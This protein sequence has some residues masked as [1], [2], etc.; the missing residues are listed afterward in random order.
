MTSALQLSPSGAS[1]SYPNSPFLRFLTFQTSNTFGSASSN[2][3]AFGASTTN[4]AFGGGNT[5]TTGF[6]QQ[7]QSSPFGAAPAQSAFGAAPVTSAFSAA[8]ATSAFGATPATSAF[9]AAPG[10]SAFGA[11]PATSGF[12]AAPASSPFGANNNTA[13]PFG[14][15][16]TSSFGAANTSTGIGG[17]GSPQNNMGGS[18]GTG[19]G[20]TPYQPVVS[21]ENNTKVSILAIT[22]SP[23]Y[24]QKSFEELRFE[25]YQKGNKGGHQQAAGGFGGA[26]GFGAS[27]APNAF[28][29]TTSPAPSAFGGGGFGASPAPA[30]GAFGAA[31]ASSAFGAAPAPSAFGAT[32]FGASPTPA[33][34]AFGGFGTPTA[35]PAPSAFGGFGTP[36]AAP[37]PSAFGGFGTPAAAPAPSAFSGFGTP[38]AA[39][40]P[41]LGG[42]GSPAAAP[43]PSAFGGFG[44]P[45]TA[46][47][48]P[49]AFGGFGAA[50]AAAPSAFGGFGA[51]PA[52]AT[53]AFGG[54]GS[55]AAAPAPSA[56]GGFGAPTAAAPATSAFGGFGAAAPA[57]NA[58]ALANPNQILVSDGTNVTSDAN[59]ASKLAYLDNQRQSLVLTASPSQPKL[60][61]NTAASNKPPNTSSLYPNVSANS[62]RSFQAG[63]N[64]AKIRPRLSGLSPVPKS[65][66]LNAPNK[67]L[68]LSPDAYLGNSTKRLVI[69]DGALTPKLKMRLQLT[70]RIS[71]GNGT[72]ASK[73]PQ[74]KNDP[75]P[76]PPT[77]SS[78]G[79]NQSPIPP[80]S[81]TV[82][83]GIPAETPHSM[84]G[85]STPGTNGSA[86]SLAPNSTK[87]TPTSSHKSNTS[88][89]FYNQVVSS[90]SAPTPVQ[91][92]A[93]V[94]RLLNN[95]YVT[96]PPFNEI[97]SMSEVEL[98]TVKDFTMTHPSR[99]SIH[100][101]GTV[102]IRGID[103]DATVMIGD[104]EVAV[105]DEE[106]EQ[107]K[108]EVGE[109]LNR[110][111]IVILYNISPTNDV[112]KFTKKLERVTKK[113]DAEFISF[114]PDE[115]V[116]T[117]RT[118]HFSRYGL[119]DD[120]DDDDDD[121][122]DTA[123]PAG[124]HTNVTSFQPPPKPLSSVPLIKGLDF[125]SGDRGGRSP[126]PQLSPFIPAGG[127][128]GSVEDEGAVM[129]KADDA[130][131]MML[132]EVLGG[133]ADGRTVTPILESAMVEISEADERQWSKDKPYKPPIWK[134]KDVTPRG[135]GGI[136]GRL[137]KEE[138]VSEKSV[139]DFQH[140]MGRGCRASFGP[141]GR[142]VRTG[143]DGSTV[144]V[145]AAGGAGKSR[146]DLLT[147]HAEHAVAE[148][149]EDGEPLPMFRLPAGLANNGT[150]DT[151]GDLLSCLDSYVNLFDGKSE[152]D[153]ERL[154]FVLMRTLYGQE[155]Y[156]YESPTVEPSKLLPIQPSSMV[157]ENRRTEGFKAFLR[158]FVGED[159]DVLIRENRD[160]NPMTAIFAALVGGRVEEA[161]EMCLEEGH[162]RLATL[163]CS[164]YSSAEYMDEQLAAWDKNGTLKKMDGQ[165]VRIYSLLAGRTS[166]NEGVLYQHGARQISWRLRLAMHLLCG[167]CGFGGERKTILDA[168]SEYNSEVERKVAPAPLG[169]GG[170]SM[171]RTCLLYNLLRLHVSGGGR[172]GSAHSKLGEVLHPHGYS[173]NEQ[174]FGLGWHVGGLLVALGVAPR[175]SGEEA[176]RFCASY[177]DDLVRV[178][179][180]AK[181]VYVLL[182][183]TNFV[184]EE[185]E[186]CVAEASRRIAR[187]IV[188]RSYADG[189]MGQGGRKWLEEL[190]V[191]GEVFEEAAALAKGWKGDSIG[192]CKAAV[193][194]GTVALAVENIDLVK[195]LFCGGEDEENLLTLL[196]Y[197][198]EGGGGDVAGWESVNGPGAVLGYLELK[199]GL[200][201]LIEKERD[202]EVVGR[203]EVVDLLDVGEDVA[204]IKDLE[205]SEYELSFVELASEGGDE[206][207]YKAFKAAVF[208]ELASKVACVRLQLKAVLT[209]DK[210]VSAQQIGDIGEVGGLILAQ[211]EVG[212]DDGMVDTT[213]KLGI[214][215]RALRVIASYLIEKL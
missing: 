11:A 31:P 49:S 62:L 159:V 53:S 117:F 4:N 180:W 209:G 91:N 19:P 141:D 104:K 107:N 115:A 133:D 6:G 200:K 198:K 210:T 9:G 73:T 110:P 172:D 173:K 24:S 184:V 132:T 87:K 34:S 156:V 205:P 26:T 161:T 181:G 29:Q 98:A 214:E 213:G 64:T 187:D 186:E 41:A 66:P 79:Y 45:A 126:G 28:G 101:Q 143:K 199:E 169:A 160:R 13:S 112:A 83:F 46:A 89:D 102:D 207:R 142:L 5:G 18:T 10:T 106:D 197:L 2:T 125:R 195:P 144:F 138:G 81:S 212:G 82:Q 47:P 162:T 170:I 74:A 139:R 59:L 97:M 127:N 38:A 36:A 40:A 174:D 65:A 182:C 37:A 94:P 14:G 69:K 193:A 80:D 188:A 123:P 86:S 122:M 116:W 21:T 15:A 30:P 158:D 154:G 3:G 178:G 130:Y 189:T 164:G 8:P 191:G 113:M 168:V 203:Q 7:Q 140:F 201:A 88:V 44:S 35:A 50:P 76:T 71:N 179:E 134:V 43:A 128:F 90:P 194:A 120:S 85:N 96:N 196:R 111:A 75:R 124:A 167:D 60:P 118:K 177:A 77:N 92:P 33:P 211:L 42:F 206:E 58:A 84:A 153:V 99:G 155:S 165:L 146:G 23:A 185:D 202:G 100:W 56:F 52:P 148:E 103:L 208:A 152:N 183:A 20:S 105:Y 190:G 192:L 151:Y 108:P 166:E 137:R 119:G 149:T 215:L 176:L 204:M 12:G 109:K 171:Q 175:M 61:P 1:A 163:L 68:L 32:G 54:F 114:D 78:L 16:G 93:Y 147:V 95:N 135:E 129:E 57:V 150:A 48:A 70:N 17:F 22:A 136:C 145:E 67:N 157:D 55:P 25:D 72:P 39:P 27:A 63:G 51:A 131:G 121:D